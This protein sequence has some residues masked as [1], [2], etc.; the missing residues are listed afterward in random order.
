M[1]GKNLASTKPPMFLAMSR[2][3]LFIQKSPP[4][5]GTTR[6]LGAKNSVLPIMASLLL[7]NG[8]SILSNVPNS[9]D[10]QQM[11][12]L[13]KNLGANINFIIE[14]NRLEINTSTIV[15]HE[16]DPDNMNKMRASILVMGPLLARFKKAQVALPGGCL[17]GTRP[18]DL[19]LQG[20]KILGVVIEQQGHFLYAVCDQRNKHSS[21]RIVLEYPSVGATENIMMCAVLT[22]GTTTIINAALEPEV[23]D[24]ITALQKMGAKI[25]CGPG[26]I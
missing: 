7:T 12:Q 20:M 26:L 1:S 6:L 3:H 22:P 23:L 24:L 4:L 19:H 2:D 18:I 13:L 21:H 25:I 9:A 11:I 5:S 14:D 15:S 10:V 17:I 16:V 8:K